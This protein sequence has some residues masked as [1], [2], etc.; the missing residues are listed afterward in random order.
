MH[1][2]LAIPTEREFNMD[3]CAGQEPDMGEVIT[4]KTFAK[5]DHLMCTLTISAHIPSSLKILDALQ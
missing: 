1:W 5:P 2:P 3:A 4:D